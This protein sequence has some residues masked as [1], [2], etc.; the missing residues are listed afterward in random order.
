M[1]NTQKNKKTKKQTKT[2]KIERFLAG[3]EFRHHRLTVV[4][5][6]PDGGPGEPG[7][8]HQ[9]G[10]V[11]FVAEDQAALQDESRCETLLG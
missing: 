2:I 1:Q 8:Q 4:L 10:V 9:G 5:E 6:H 3:E 11:Q 7:P